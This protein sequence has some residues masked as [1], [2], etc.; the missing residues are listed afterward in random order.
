MDKN[1]LVNNY[2]TDDE[3]NTLIQSMLEFANAEVE[4]KVGIFWYD[5]ENDELFGVQSISVSKEKFDSNGRKTIQILHI[6]YWKKKYNEAKYK[7]KKNRFFGDYTK[8]PRGRIFQLQNGTFEVMV[9]SWINKYPSVKND[10][11]NEFDLPENKTEF[12]IDRHW[13]VGNGWS[14]ELLQGSENS[15]SDKHNYQDLLEMA[16]VG[17]TDDQY[18]IYVNTDDS[19]KIPHFHYRKKNEWDKFHTCIKIEKAEYFLHG[20]K[21][22]KLNSRQKKELIIFLNKKTNR[23]MRNWDHIVDMWNMNNSD[24]LVDESTKMPNYNNL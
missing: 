12:I 11:I 2:T 1:I 5:A 10:I 6:D 13:E 19:G 23:N 22:D 4:P 7:N 17:F 9:G 18:E 20:G 15:M 8:I 14:N 3:H 24:V 16:R 21:N